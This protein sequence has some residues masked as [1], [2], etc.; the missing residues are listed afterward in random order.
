[1]GWV[2]LGRVAVR[3]TLVMNAVSLSTFLLLQDLWM[4]DF[5]E[6]CS[7]TM[8]KTTG[9]VIGYIYTWLFV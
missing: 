7:Q 5:R 4:R 1:M 3:Q 2:E 6:A 8:I 9:K